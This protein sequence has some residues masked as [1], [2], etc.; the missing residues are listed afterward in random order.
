MATL[1]ASGSIDTDGTIVS[2]EFDL[3]KG[4]GLV[5]YGLQEEVTE[6]YGV[7]AYNL[8]LR[9]TDNSGQQAEDTATILVNPQI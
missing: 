2:Y 9:V 8:R 7:G 5:N 3:G 1:D 6:F 4:D